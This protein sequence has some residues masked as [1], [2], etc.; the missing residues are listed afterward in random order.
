M[1]K[2]LITKPDLK[3]NVFTHLKKIIIEENKIF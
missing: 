2:K 1:K 3:N